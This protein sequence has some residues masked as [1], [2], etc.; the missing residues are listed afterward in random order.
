MEKTPQEL[1]EYKADQKKSLA[2]CVVG[3]KD[4]NGYEILSVFSKTDDW[5]I[6]EIKT[7]Q[8]ID[9]LKILIYTIDPDDPK[10]IIDNFNRIRIAFIK[11]KGVLYKIQDYS[12][13]KA[14]AAHLL[15]HGLSGKVDD[16]I[17]QFDD[18]VNEIDTEYA[19]L[20]K[21][22]LTYLRTALAFVLLNIILSLLVYANT[23]FSSMPLIRT[24]IFVSTGGSIGGFISV[25]RNLK[26]TIFEKG[27][28]TGIYITY[29]LERIFISIF[30]AVVI[31]FAISSNLIFGAVKK[32][33]PA[34]YGYLAFAI[35]AGFSETLVP[36]LLIRLENKK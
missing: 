18:L 13:Y 16:V 29:A 10:K 2:S 22:R 25:S 24:L 35:V 6:Y 27:V 23:L 36:N 14:L 17:G 32:L 11:F 21:K 1:A 5:V 4:D 7:P 33:E 19:D 28:G 26:K 15:A 9:S 3:K 30:A 8:V 34:I 31:Y 12:S 20:F